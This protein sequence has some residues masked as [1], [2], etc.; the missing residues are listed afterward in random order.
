MSRPRGANAP[1][2]EGA[3]QVMRDRDRGAQQV[4]SRTIPGRNRHEASAG[5]RGR[6][7]EWE[8]F[9]L[10][11][12]GYRAWTATRMPAPA[13]RSRPRLGVKARAPVG[14]SAP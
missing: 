11:G 14:A 3:A 13:P 5:K 8:Q 6:L 9:P 2:H 10:F 7:T 12:V 4:R 1:A